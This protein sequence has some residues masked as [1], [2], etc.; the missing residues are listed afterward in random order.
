[1]F[2]C[3]LRNSVLTDLLSIFDRRSNLFI[4]LFR[5]ITMTQNEV[6]STLRAAQQDYSRQK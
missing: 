6:D 3:D 5:V 4:V 2:T 1:M